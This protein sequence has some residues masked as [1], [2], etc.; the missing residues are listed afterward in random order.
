MNTY[1]RWQKS[2]LTEALNQDVE[3]PWAK[4][5]RNSDWKIRCRNRANG[6]GT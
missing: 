4:T 2:V 3:L 1:R 6:G 5:T